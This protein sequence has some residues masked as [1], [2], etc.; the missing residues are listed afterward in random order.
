MNDLLKTPDALQSGYWIRRRLVRGFSVY[1]L[2][3]FG[4]R[5]LGFALLVFYSRFLSPHDFG[6]VSI[7]ESIGAGIG[8][9]AGL[10][11]EAGCRRLY[12]NFA[13]DTDQLHSYLSTVIRLAATAGII[14]LITS[15]S[16]GPWILRRA[17][18][19]WHSGFFPYLALPILTAIV[20][21]LLACRLVIFQCQERLF[22]F[23]SFVVL[24]SFLTTLLTF[25]LVAWKHEGAAGLL[26]SRAIGACLTLAIA[27]CGSGQLLRAQCRWT[28]VRETL[29]VS[30]PLVLHGLMALGLVAI[31]RFIL[32][33]YRS[34]SEVGL[35]SV[36][37]SI[38]LIM[39][40]VTASLNRAWAPLFYSLLRDNDQ[41]RRIAGNIGSELILLLSL[42]AG[43]GVLLAPLCIDR[44]FDV[45]YW[46]AAEIAPV[47]LGAY[48][49]H[50]LFSIFQLS[51]IQARRTGLVTLVSGMALLTNIALNFAWIPKYGM[52]GAAYATLGGYAVELALIAI[53][54]QQVLRL[55]YG[56][57]RPSLAL[58][59]G[60]SATVWTRFA[61]ATWV[62][63]MFAALMITACIALVSFHFLERANPFR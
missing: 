62:T 26:T 2:T 39:T 58:F 30:L 18:P 14:T 48:L 59:A 12:F 50:S 57:K 47:L 24:Q 16:L 7:A 32:Q 4:L 21:Q 29:Q 55:P 51:L 43:A 17:F 38:G 60:A 42:I 35:Y 8:V 10:A 49:C 46:P 63:L 25:C 44:F 33:H 27:A 56:W 61:P 45:R 22:A 54:A 6:I 15:Y 3:Y 19:G 34:L 41:D 1:A 31:D 9:V 40:L 23:N 28:Y 20:S 11:L 37:Y 52:I 36:A 13:E 5:A 53:F